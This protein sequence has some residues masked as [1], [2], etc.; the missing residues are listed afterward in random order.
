MCGEGVEEA[1]ERVVQGRGSTMAAFDSSEKHDFNCWFRT[2]PRGHVLGT[3][4]FRGLIEG[5]M[6]LDLVHV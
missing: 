3:L 6:R 5:N 2:L 4:L 1:T